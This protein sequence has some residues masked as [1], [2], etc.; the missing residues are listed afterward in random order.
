MISYKD[1]KEARVQIRLSGDLISSFQK[2]IGTDIREGLID[3][4]IERNNTI[5]GIE[6]LHSVENRL[7]KSISLKGENEMVTP[8]PPWGVVV[9]EG[10][11]IEKA[12]SRFY[13]ARSKGAALFHIPFDTFSVKGTPESR[14]RFGVQ[15]AQIAALLKKHSIASIRPGSY[16]G[17]VPESLL[18]ESY[19]LDHLQMIASQGFAWVEME[20]TIPDDRLAQLIDIAKKASSKVMITCL[21]ES[22][23]EWTPPDNI[24]PDRLDGYRIIIPMEDSRGLKRA[25]R[26]SLNARKWARGKK[27]LVDP[28]RGSPSLSKIFG[29]LSLSD[30][31]EVGIGDVGSADISKN[32][33]SGINEIWESMGIVGQGVGKDWS[34][35]GRKMTP[36]SRIYLQVGKIS[37][38]EYRSKIFNAQ[39]NKMSLDGLMIPWDSS[40]SRIITCIE[41]AKK[42]G[43]NGAYIEMP[44]RSSAVA[45]MD[46]VDHRSMSVGSIDVVKFNGMNAN[47][48]NSEIY[49]IGDEIALNKIARSSKTIIIGT[50]ASGRSAA[51]AAAMMGMDTYIAGNNKERTIDIANRLEG[52]IKGTSF[53]AL[54]KPMIKFQF[55]INS[56]PF[57][58]K[59]VRGGSDQMMEI[60]EIVKR[61]EPEFGM[62]LFPKIRWTPF[63]SSIES[64]GGTP[65]SGVDVLTGSS[66]RAFK[67]MTGHDPN[68]EHLT[69]II[70]ETVLE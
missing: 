63:L 7:L 20:Q 46:W 48:Y 68:D 59:T 4:S 37:G 44:F 67:L 22:M 29:P 64:R 69:K 23:K 33:L 54:T 38:S 51:V 53:K 15:I 47:G 60:A 21:L 65:I 24:D 55:I 52:N 50:G 2:D 26:A 49:G 3:R 14:A 34:M 16:G 39:F 70:E 1:E 43:V 41:N 12:R 57:E 19:R 36:E 25:Y 42:M 56:I 10:P 66:K 11:S 45:Q 40:D 31:V 62:D 6:D 18:P 5:N 8:V 32:D 30:M 61:F 9:L 27:I 58:S 28:T 13:K 17:A 35:Y